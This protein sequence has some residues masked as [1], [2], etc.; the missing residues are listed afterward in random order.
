M[1]Q[2]AG[3]DVF[4]PLSTA[5]VSAII[6]GVSA[7]LD[8]HLASVGLGVPVTSPSSLTG[9]LLVLNVYGAAAEIQRTRYAHLS[10]ANAESAWKFF[11]DRYKT[12][13]SV[14][15]KMA[16]TLASD[17]EEPSSYTTLYPDE[18]SDLGAN[19]EPSLSVSMEW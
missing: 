6:D 8:A 15:D 16:S 2:Q 14:L 11:E 19:A 7:T 4:A 10:G 17:A 5:D 12:G 1:P 9:Y 18:D 3:A 13:L